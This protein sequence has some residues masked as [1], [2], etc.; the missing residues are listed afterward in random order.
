MDDIAPALIKASHVNPVLIPR[1]ALPLGVVHIVETCYLLTSYI[2]DSPSRIVQQ[3]EQAPIHA[4]RARTYNYL[5]REHLHSSKL[6]K[7]LGKRKPKLVDS[8]VGNR[9]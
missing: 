5:R 4:V 9:L 7:E 8:V 6:V 2:L 3:A 1:N